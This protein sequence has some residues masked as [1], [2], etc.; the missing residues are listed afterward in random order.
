MKWG[1]VSTIV[2]VDFIDEVDMDAAEAQLDAVDL[3][4]LIEEQAA[5]LRAVFRSYPHVASTG[6]LDI[7]CAGVTQH[8]IELY[9]STPIRQHP[10]RFPIAS[11]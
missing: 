6:D 11:N 9:D 2:E 4:H 3:S 10:R 5:K 8:K 7:G 1:Q